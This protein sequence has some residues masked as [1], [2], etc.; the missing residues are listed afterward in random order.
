[1]FLCPC[2]DVDHVEHLLPIATVCNRKFYH[3]LAL[4]IRGTILKKFFKQSPQ[5]FGSHKQCPT[6]GKLV[7][8]LTWK[9]E[10]RP[11]TSLR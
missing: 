5:Q 2:Y 8:M 1:M 11:P 9:Q 4:E 6:M 7:V 3:P 10:L